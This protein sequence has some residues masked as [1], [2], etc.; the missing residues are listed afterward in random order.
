MQL[1]DKL[2]HLARL[3]SYKSNPEQRTATDIPSAYWNDPEFV[4]W[5]CIKSSS[6]LAP[7]STKLLNDISAVP[8]ISDLKYAGPSIR[9]NR[10]VVQRCI[11]RNN[12]SQLQYAPDFKADRAI[13]LQAAQRRGAAYIDPAFK[14]DKQFVLDTVKVNGDFLKEFPDFID[15]EDVVRVAIGSGL[16]VYRQLNE[17]HRAAKWVVQLANISLYNADY[18]P[19][20]ARKDGKVHDPLFA[21][22]ILCNNS[23]AWELLSPERQAEDEFLWLAFHRTYQSSKYDDPKFANILKK[24]VVERGKY[25]KILWHKVSDEALKEPAVARIALWASAGKIQHRI[26]TEIMQDRD[27]IISLL[28]G[29]LPKH[30][31]LPERFKDDIDLARLAVAHQKPSSLRWFS[32]KV[33]GN[34]QLIREIGMRWDGILEH[35]TD[36]LKKD[37][38]LVAE[39]L[40]FESQNLKYVDPSLLDSK[41]LAIRT[42]YGNNSRADLNLFSSRLRDDKEVVLASLVAKGGNFLAAS[43]RLQQDMEL[44]QKAVAKDPHIL[45]KIPYQDNLA[46]L[47]IGVAFNG[48]SYQYAS[49]KLRSH[50]DLTAIAVSKRYSVMEHASEKLKTHIPFLK[51]I[52]KISL[53]ALKYVDIEY[54][55]QLTSLTVVSSTYRNRKL[56]SDVCPDYHV[57]DGARDVA[58]TT[59]ERNGVVEVTIQN[60]SV[61]EYEEHGPC[62]SYLCASAYSDIVVCGDFVFYVSTRGLDGMRSAEGGHFGMTEEKMNTVDRTNEIW[63][64]EIPGPGVV[65]DLSRKKNKERN[66]SRDIAEQP[67]LVRILK[68]ENIIFPQGLSTNLHNYYETLQEIG[69]TGTGDLFSKHGTHRKGLYYARA[70]KNISG[71]CGG[72]ARIQLT[73]R[74][75][76]WL[77]PN[78]NGFYTW[79]E[80]TARIKATTHRDDWIALRENHLVDATDT[81]IQ[82]VR[83]HFSSC[84]DFELITEVNT[85][86]D[87]LANKK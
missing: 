39:V 17:K 22:R 76:R 15:D 74:E 87:K 36:E 2:T 43:E 34:K 45:S 51:R 80:L 35:A 26:P 27:F 49:E 19:D 32:A 29:H 78:Q 54:R 73:D 48:Y 4:N 81:E 77:I 60:L 52:Q 70:P 20:N 31:S 18:F 62:G 28:Y 53:D 79:E 55:K 58:E 84:E 30:F 42:F 5:V 83:K 71:N 57:Y 7:A 56:I 24:V 85:Y 10:E 59:I 50:E 69:K 63:L 8:D 12:G 64:I 68:S 6:Y 9:K 41:E 37:M 23:D 72:A 25:P 16:N 46:V 66:G 44:V 3:T 67:N 13:A 14:K 40:E 82:T 33:R 75:F 38:E 61:K 86:L 11:Q 47:M 21:M 65:L 1:I